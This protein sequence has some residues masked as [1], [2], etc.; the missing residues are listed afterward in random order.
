VLSGEHI[1]AKLDDGLGAIGR[2]FANPFQ[3]FYVWSVYSTITRVAL[4]AT[5]LGS[6]GLPSI[7]V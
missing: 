7:S 4:R 6:V 3:G 1:D 5:F 2:R